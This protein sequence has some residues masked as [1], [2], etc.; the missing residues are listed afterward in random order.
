MAGTKDWADREMLWGSIK[1]IWLAN[2]TLDEKILAIRQPTP[3]SNYVTIHKSLHLSDTP[4]SDD[5]PV[6]HFTTLCQILHFIFLDFQTAFVNTM[7]FPMLPPL[8]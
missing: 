2:M 6:S 5:L 3:L 8:P 1:I 4:F 7:Y